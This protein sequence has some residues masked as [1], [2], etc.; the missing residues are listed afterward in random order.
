MTRIDKTKVL[1]AAL[2]KVKT[3]IGFSCG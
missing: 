1:P 2:L 3:L